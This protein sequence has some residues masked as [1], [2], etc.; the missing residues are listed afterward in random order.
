MLGGLGEVVA[1]LVVGGRGVWA[2][3]A[4]AGADYAQSFVHG[5]SSYLVFLFGTVWGWLA[6]YLF[7]EGLLRIASGAAG[8]PLGLLPLAIARFAARRLRRPAKLP[9][10]VV[11]RDGEAIV[12]D[13]AHDYDWH[14]LTTVE[15]DGAHYA[16]AREPG[17][18]LRPH[19][20]RLTPIG[21][22]HVVRTITRYPITT[23]RG[24]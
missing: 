17:A 12:I 3:R 6:I 21:D 16:V 4:G 18:P 23:T 24:G 20:Y 14:A 22:G 11:T 5:A 13:S 15:I 1:G 7:V 10:D 9:D 2:H 8:E 19:R